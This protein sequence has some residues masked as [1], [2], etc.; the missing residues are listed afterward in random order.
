MNVELSNINEANSFF[1]RAMTLE[2]PGDRD[3]AR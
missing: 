3:A 1:F 2:K